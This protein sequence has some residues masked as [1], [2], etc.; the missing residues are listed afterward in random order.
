[1]MKLS[2]PH[3]HDFARWRLQANICST[4]HSEGFVYGSQLVNELLNGKG[5]ALRTTQL[6]LNGE[7]DLCDDWF[8]LLQPSQWAY[9]I[10]DVAAEDHTA[11]ASSANT[12][13]LSL[14]YFLSIVDLSMY[15]K[16][17]LF[18]APLQ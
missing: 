8:A 9:F 17:Y 10:C 4:I 15:H 16:T 6:W 14:H 7:E 12:C 11:D 5:K 18:F 2:A 1:M 3:K 13:P